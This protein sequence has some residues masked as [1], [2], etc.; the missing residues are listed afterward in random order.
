MTTSQIVSAEDALMEALT[1]GKVDFSFRPR[2][3][4]VDDESKTAGNDEGDAFT[5]R[6]TLGYKT[7]SF[8]KFFRYA[9]FE[10]VSD[11]TDDNQYND[12]QNGLTQLPVIA[13]PSGTEVNRAYL[14]TTLIP[15]TLIKAGRQVITPRKAPFHRF[16][17]NV[18]WRQNWQTQ[19]AVTLTNTS[20]PNTKIMAGYIWNNNTIFGTNRDMSAPIFNVQFKGLK[21]AALEGYYYDLEFD[22]LPGLSTETYGIRAA[23]G[24]PIINESTKLIYTGEY[25]MQKEGGN[26]TT[27]YDADYYLFEGGIKTTFKDSFITSVMAKVSYEVLEGDGTNAFQTPL[28]TG[29]AYQ[30]WADNFL[31]TPGTGI[32]DT[33]F[34]MVATGKYNTKLI[35]SYHMLEAETASFDY[36][37]ELDIWFTKKFAKHY[38]I[39]LKYAAYDGSSDALNTA[40]STDLTKYWVY[41]AFKY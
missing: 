12:T 31:R 9:E 38:T 25:A 33:Y 23:G 20:L 14:G 27:S 36:G 26:S 13:D 37:D 40:K 8:H 2:Y 18:L 6:T 24:F 15:E 5:V 19:D 7:G 29:H 32:E 17:G 41:F 11:I 21:Y 22:D 34:T 10:N 16:L 30:G 1:G 39:G 28:A 4:F 35:V 3:E